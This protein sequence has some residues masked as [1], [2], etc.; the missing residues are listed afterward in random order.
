MKPNTGHIT[1]VSLGPGDPDLITVKGIRALQNADRIYFPGSLFSDGRK[2]SYSEEILSHY[3]LDPAKWRGF[4]LEMSL[5][6]QQANRV[7]DQTAKAIHDDWKNGLKV[8]IVSEG[9]VNTYSSFSYVLTRLQD[10]QIEVALIP[11]I[12]SY[13][14]GAAVS[15]TILGLQNDKLMI[16]P[17]VQS[18]EDL[19]E[20]LGSA[21]TVV[22]MKIRSVMDTIESVLSERKC[23][24]VYCERLGTKQEFITSNWEEVSQRTIPYF[25]L[26]IIQA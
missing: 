1:G 13:N 7:Y 26:I 17:R 2:A 22:L 3:E 20:A 12:T 6:R 9:D 21:K 18:K 24:F 8:V 23:P 16:L 25:S 11:G 4:Y 14:L 5:D 19:E 15:S 10:M